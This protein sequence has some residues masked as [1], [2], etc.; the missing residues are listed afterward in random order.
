MLQKMVQPK[1]HHQHQKG[2][3]V[4]YVIIIIIFSRFEIIF[5]GIYFQWFKVG[6]SFERIDYYPGHQQINSVL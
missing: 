3:Q 4:V 2:E 5:D 1:T 6:I